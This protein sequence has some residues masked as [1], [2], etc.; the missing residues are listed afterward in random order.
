MEESFHKKIHAVVKPYD[1][2]RIVCDYMV[3]NTWNI[4]R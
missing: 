4:T 3:S 1:F 2:S